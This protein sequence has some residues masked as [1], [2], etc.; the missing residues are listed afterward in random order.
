MNLRLVINSTTSHVLSPPQHLWDLDQNINTNTFNVLKSTEL[1]P[2]P[3]HP[4]ARPQQQFLP[5]MLHCTTIQSKLGITRVRY[6]ISSSLST[7]PALLP[8]SPATSCQV[9]NPMP[10]SLLIIKARFRMVINPIM[11]IQEG[12]T[13]TK[14]R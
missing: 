6:S 1:E 7:L 2:I 8:N 11:V 14:E 13:S 4:A 10:L 12:S 3:C 9:S 5:T